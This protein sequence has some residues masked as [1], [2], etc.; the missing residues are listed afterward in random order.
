MVV[1]ILVFGC[2]N[3]LLLVFAMNTKI[4]GKIIYVGGGY[5]V[6]PTLVLFQAFSS[7]CL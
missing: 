1:C 4:D 2:F 5:I 3:V 6:K 7:T